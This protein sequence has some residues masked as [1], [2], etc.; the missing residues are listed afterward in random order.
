MKFKTNFDGKKIEF[1]VL[2]PVALNCINRDDNNEVKTIEIPGSGRRQR[3]SSQCWKRAIR[4]QFSKNLGIKCVS[5]QLQELV[6][7]LVKKAGGSDNIAKKIAV[8]FNENF[9]DI[10]K[11]ESS[12]EDSDETQFKNNNTLMHISLNELN[13]VIEKCKELGW[14][15]CLKMKN[16]KEVFNFD[17]N[18][19]VN[20]FEKEIDIALFG[21][22]V[23]ANTNNTI[24]A[25]TSWNHAIS[26]NEIDYYSDYFTADIDTQIKDSHNGSTMIGNT[27]FA[28]PSTLYRYFNID[29]GTYYKNK[30]GNIEAMKEEIAEFIR[31]SLFS[32][33]S[34]RQHG[35]CTVNRP[36]YVRID[37]INGFPHQIP[38]ERESFNDNIL[39]N[40]IKFINETLES[41]IEIDGVKPIKTFEFCR[42]KKIKIQNSTSVPEIITNIQNYIDELTK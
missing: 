2:H 12:K 32:M 28:P 6:Q 25:A 38:F 14:D 4:D 20:N 33:P 26:I 17:F 30:N 18:T 36:D 27:S 3:V 35:M 34:A 42:D 1:N 15:K 22:M 16:K 29:L 8:L 5:S 11:K 41:D 10:A 7:E 31:T 37:I 21:R 13:A 19:L 9:G 39:E 24:E 40:G 23:A